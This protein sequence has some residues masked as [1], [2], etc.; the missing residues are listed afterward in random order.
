MMNLPGIQTNQTYS[1]WLFI[2]CHQYI[3]FIGDRRQGKR[4]GMGERGIMKG[5]KRRVKE[6]QM[7]DREEEGT[8]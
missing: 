2:E 7:D 1:R 5:T 4:G 8:G 6:T 3:V